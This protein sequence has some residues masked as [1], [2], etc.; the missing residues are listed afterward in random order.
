MATNEQPSIFSFSP[1]MVPTSTNPKNGD[2]KVYFSSDP[3]YALH[4]EILLLVL[5]LLFTSLIFL[6]LLIYTRRFRD[7]NF[8]PHKNGGLKVEPCP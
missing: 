2:D 1:S 8:I 3:K 6:A 7:D 5:V 4:G